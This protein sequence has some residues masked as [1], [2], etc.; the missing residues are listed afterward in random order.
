MTQYKTHAPT[1][2][3]FIDPKVIHDG[4]QIPAHVTEKG[5]PGE[6]DWE[7]TFQ[8]D[9][10]FTGPFVWKVTTIDVCPKVG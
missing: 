1:C 9:E 3:R 5:T 8:T 4:R 10:F 7:W 6:T 2:L